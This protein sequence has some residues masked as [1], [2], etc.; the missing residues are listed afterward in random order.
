MPTTSTWNN[1]NSQNVRP[2]TKIA[3][4]VT[5]NCSATR[6]F[7]EGSRLDSCCHNSQQNNK[8][9][10]NTYQKSESAKEESPNYQTKSSSQREHVDTHTHTKSKARATQLQQMPANTTHNRKP[11]N[12]QL[13]TP[14]LDTC[15]QVHIHLP[16][17]VHICRGIYAC[18]YVCMYVG[19][20]ILILMRIYDLKACLRNNFSTRRAVWL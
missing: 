3:G 13:Q 1:Q 17:H 5:R 15:M 2:S 12:A 19:V 8:I 9:T 10:R 11:K 6:E 7:A 14:Q 18:M 20:P 16:F 4:Q